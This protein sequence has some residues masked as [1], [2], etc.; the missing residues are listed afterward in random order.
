MGLQATGCPTGSVNVEQGVNEFVGSE[1]IRSSG[2]SPVRTNFTGMPARAGT[3]I[4][5]P[6]LAVPSSLV[7]TIPVTVTPR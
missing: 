7:N 2:P 5:M 4:T 3:A 6:P 1:P